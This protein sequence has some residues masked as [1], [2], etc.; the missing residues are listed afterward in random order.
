MSA[1]LVLH[2]I[3][4]RLDNSKILLDATSHHLNGT[5]A[6]NPHVVPD[7]K[8]GSCLLFD[9]V[10][11]SATVP[12]SERLRLQ[13]YTAE[14]W[15]K[16]EQPGDW[17]GILGKP[18]RNF[19][20][21]L[22]PH[23]F[24]HHR[25]HA[26]ADWN[27][28]APDTANSSI[29]WGK[30]HHVAITNNGQMA[31][32]YIDGNLAAEGPVSGGLIA[33]PTPLIVGRHLD[34][35]QSQYYQGHMA[36]LRLYDNALTPDD[37]RRDMAQDESAASAFVRSHA[38]D[39]ELYN[40]NNHHVLFIDNHPQGQTL[41]LDIHN[42]SR[43]SIELKDLGQKATPHAHHFELRFRPET[44]AR[45]N[46]AQIKVA[47][48][49]WSL[50]HAAD[51]TALYLLHQGST[52][53]QAGQ[54]ISLQL[55]G[56]NA[57]GRGG[58]RGTRVELVY[59]NLNYIG[60]ASLLTGS[61]LQYL[62]IV[63][64]LGRPNIPLHVG[65]VGSNTVL[66]DGQ[67]PNTLRL[68]IANLSR[69]AGLRLSKGDSTTPPSR[70]R[71][72]FDVQAAGETSEWA[73]INYDNVEG[74]QLRVA[75]TRGVS[76]N[77][78]DPQKRSLAQ[79]VEWTIAPSEDTTLAAEGYLLLELSSLVA[80]AS[81]GHAPI[82]INYENIPGY[83]DG[84]V[85]IVAQK[86]PLLYSNNHVGIGLDNPGQPL[87]IN[88]T[89]NSGRQPDSGMSFGGTLAIR[90][91]APQIDF[92]DTTNNDWS[93]HVNDNKMYFIRE[94]WNHTDFVL[95][96]T[97]NVG[98]GTA[99]PVG[100]LQIIN[101]NQDA[102]GNTLVLGP[103]DHSNLRLGY[104]QDYSWI[105][106]HGNKPLVLNPA[107]HNV[108]I[109][110]HNPDSYKLKVEG[111][112][113]HLG[114]ALH[115]AANQEIL[116]EDN[117][118]IGSL[119]HHHRILFRRA[120]NKMELR[121]Y[122]DLIFSPGATEGTETAKMVI[123]AAGN[124][125][126]GTM[127]PRQQLVLR[128][129]WDTGKHGSMS[130]GGSL[131]IISNAPQIDFI[132]TDRSDE[133]NDRDWSIHVNGSKMYFVREPWEYTDLV[134]DGRGSVGIGTDNP[135]S[136]LEVVGDL[137]LRSHNN[138]FRMSLAEDATGLIFEMQNSRHG[139]H[140]RVIWDGDKNWDYASDRRLKT[141]I[142]NEANI[143]NRLMGLA[144]KNYR[145]KDS[146][147]AQ[148][149]EIGFIAQEVQPVFPTLVGEFKHPEEAES[150]LTLKYADFA[151]L[152]VGGLKELKQEKDAEIAE[153]RNKMTA[154]IDDLKA[155]IRRMENR[156]VDEFD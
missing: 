145:W 45:A 22:H 104:H 54:T 139:S 20:I 7:E 113:T 86:S 49:G 141:D 138:E 114:S 26:G 72:S 110:T 146:P 51:G 1:N 135:G 74:V 4:D 96:G 81:I 102:H 61:R 43:Q 3:L 126:I 79:T 87:V 88:G 125:G 117:G 67:T 70:L 8:F 55:T 46:L 148:A 16:A 150:T 15:I 92:I 101:G 105:Q 97:G 10:G 130:H 137:K 68:R 60:E 151:V 156:A 52:T 23:G 40:E 84:Q 44:L 77:W 124:V 76:A 103:T 149:K 90:S 65:F 41:S 2:W 142:D 107:G 56:M 17:V 5:Y 143:L 127:N 144:V 119:D 48:A 132:D 83:R 73:L 18:G 131:A 78:A 34:D 42:S 147:K 13:S 93:I 62:N 75:Q 106:S 152:A 35:Q 123:S 28:G 47:T 120:Q 85:T 111:G 154:E 32:T 109:G 134:L 153:L 80:L 118:Q 122:G 39:F 71:L 129:K 140:K 133:G 31:R 155:Q 50:D 116:F 95:D 12:D 128:G 33:D 57:D 53:L 14:V 115:L 11:D 66:S 91:D 9:G 30:W 64:H 89:H 94:P 24:I 27:A 98:I 25:F 38:L 59:D 58:T 108:G 6:G 21:W 136:K 19:N 69:D 37:I 99:T 100:K 82:Y 63:N 112:N 121:E 36:H 29:T